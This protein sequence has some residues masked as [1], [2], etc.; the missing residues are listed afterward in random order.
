[1]ASVLRSAAGLLSGSRSHVRRLLLLSSGRGASQHS[2]ASAQ[3][4]SRVRIVEV[5]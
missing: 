2:T 1:M 5:S 4:P 3:M